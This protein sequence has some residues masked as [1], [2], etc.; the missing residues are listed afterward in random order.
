MPQPVNSSQFHR[1]VDF[2]LCSS[3]SNYQ[4]G[5]LLLPSMYWLFLLL[6]K[7]NLKFKCSWSDSACVHSCKFPTKSTVN[8]WGLKPT[9]KKTTQLVASINVVTVHEDERKNRLVFHS[10]VA[11]LLA[12]IGSKGNDIMGRVL[13]L[14]QIHVFLIS[15]HSLFL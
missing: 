8:C 13:W 7:K 1:K 12:E 4:L 11:T 14:D 10:V 9:V 15:V 2:V 5:V 6:R 3:E